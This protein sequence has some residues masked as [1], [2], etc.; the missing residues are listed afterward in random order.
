MD[1]QQRYSFP[2]RPDDEQLAVYLEQLEHLLGNITTHAYNDVRQGFSQFRE[3]AGTPTTD[4]VQTG[5]LAFGDISGT[6][7]IFVN[8]SGTLYKVALTAV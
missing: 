7:Y 4:E 8:L 3:F 5:E 6:K 1:L 2:P